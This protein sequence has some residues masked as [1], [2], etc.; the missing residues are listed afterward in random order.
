MDAQ[1]SS[2][3]GSYLSGATEGYDFG[4][5]VGAMFGF[6]PQLLVN[7]L[8]RFSAVIANSAACFQK[9]SIFRMD[10][11]YARFRYF[12]AQEERESYKWIS[13]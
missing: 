9:S 10:L 8:W 12:A 6:G 7:T 11:R 3:S 5:K 13:H 1:A 4:N 2:E